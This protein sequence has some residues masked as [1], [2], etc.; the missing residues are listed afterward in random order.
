[1]PDRKRSAAA[2]HAVHGFIV[3][4]ANPYSSTE[5]G[6]VTNKPGIDVGIGSTG[7]ACCRTADSHAACSTAD[8]NILQHISSQVCCF[9]INNTFG[10]R[11]SFVQNLTLTV[12]NLQ[13]SNR[14]AIHTIA[15][16]NAVGCSHFQ[17]INALAETAECHSEVCIAVGAGINQ[18]SNTH[19]FGIADNF[20]YTNL[21]GQLNGRHVHRTYQSSTQAYLT[22]PCSVGV[23]RLPAGREFFFLI[24][25]NAG[26]RITVLHCSQVDKRLEGRTGLTYCKSSTV[27]FILAAAADHSFNVTVMRVNC[28]QSH[29]RLSQLL[30]VCIIAR[31]MLHGIFCSF[32]HIRV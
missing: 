20:A 16:Q 30:A 4:I 3:V 15:C 32:L 9:G 11:L 8:K 2:V 23:L 26:R 10:F 28:N 13:Q 22:M 14:L 21:L 31:Q 27:E 24:F 7:F 18:S 25:N 29:L 12:N 6:S 1:M 19:F 5:V 17:G